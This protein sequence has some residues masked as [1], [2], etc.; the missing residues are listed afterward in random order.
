MG[1]MEVEYLRNRKHHLPIG[2]LIVLLSFGPSFLQAEQLEQQTLFYIERSKNANIVQYDAQVG[3]DGR[4]DRKKPVVAY[5]IRLAEQGQHKKLSWIQRKF[6][7]GFKDKLDQD[8]LGVSL[9]MVAGLGAPIRVQRVGEGF[10]A[11]I[12]IDGRPSR[13]EKIYVDASGKWLSV[14]IGYIELYGRDLETGEETYQRF[15]P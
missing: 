7:Y 11:V 12:D 13:L 14:K 1:I 3:P 8:Q 2:Y 15:I 10:K 4:L 5:W 9:D 6:A